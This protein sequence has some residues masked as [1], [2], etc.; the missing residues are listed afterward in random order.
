MPRSHLMDNEHFRREFRT[1]ERVVEPESGAVR[2]AAGG[3]YAAVADTGTETVSAYLNKRLREIGVGHVMAIPGDYISEW[4]ESLDGESSAGLKRVHPN[5]EMLATYAAD[6]YGR[7]VGDSVGCV[8][9]TYGVG[10]LNAVQAVAGAYVENVP[11]VIVNGSPSPAQFNSQRDQGVLWH[12][13]F[14]GSYTDLRVFQEVTARA[15]RVDNPAY[16]PELIDAALATCITE[17][18]PVYIEIANGMEGYQCQA[19]SMRQG[20]TPTP[21][22]QSKE[23]L[24]EAVNAVIEVLKSSK[25]LVILGGIELSRY[26]L[27]DKLVTLA[28]R[29]QAPYVSSLLGKSALSEFRKDIR[30]SGVYNGRNSQANV[31]KLMREADVVLQLGVLETDF[32]FSGVATADFDPNTAPGLPMA[33]QVDVRQGAVKINTAANPAQ[34]GELYWGDVSLDAF[35]GA[36]AE[37]IDQQLGGKPPGAPYPGLD[38]GTPWEI[39]GPDEYSDNDQVTWDSFKSYLQH[40]YLSRFQESDQPVLLADTGLTFYALNNLKVPEGGYIAQLSWGAIGY[41]VGANYG[42]KLAHDALSQGSGRRVI[43]VCGDGAFAESV[44]ALG[45]IAQLGLDSIV[46]VMANGVFAIEQFLI[47]ADAYCDN[48]PPPQFAALTD[49]PQT[50]IW[51]WTKLAEGFGGVG[52][53]VTTNAELAEVL[54]QLEKPPTNAATGKPTFTLIAVHNKRKDLPSNTRWKMRCG[55]A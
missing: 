38:S 12:H 24:D 48:A 21:V 27:Q 5:N 25:R 6:G 41:T 52:Y 53:T 30:F 43:S 32:N 11:L 39:P 36:L 31:Q 46:F 14:D 51:D 9:V 15:V 44:N 37:A 20:L 7:A 47:D 23:S 2:A 50:S 13:M 4:V 33:G 49:V 34:T 1:P 42:V 3:D 8:A 55:K 29:L 10:A 45:T 28:K 26:S 19:V 22:P 35:L 54:G 16:A 17:N 18:R 40:R